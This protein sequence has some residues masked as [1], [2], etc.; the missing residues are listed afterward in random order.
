[1]LISFSPDCG[2]Y[3]LLEVGNAT[4]RNMVENALDYL[5][6]AGL[7]GNRSAGQGRF[8]VDFAAPYVP[9][10]PT[11]GK[12][13]ITLSLYH[14][15]LE[16]LDGGVLAE[17]AAYE[18]GR[19]DGWA[20]SPERPGQRRRSTWFVGEGSVLRSTGKE[21]YGEL[22]DVTPVSGPGEHS[23]YRY[24]YAFPIGVQGQ[25]MSNEP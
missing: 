5:S 2:F 20:G 6:E 9:F 10:W 25:G 22:V 11:A 21:S 15:T 16:E 17:G 23:V 24:G 14:P 18:L 3:L 4:S 12:M 7:G 8:S 13:F 19:R 1:M